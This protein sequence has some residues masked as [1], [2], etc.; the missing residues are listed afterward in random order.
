VDNK[1]KLEIGPG[2]R[3]IDKSWTTLGVVAPKRAVDVEFEWGVQ[4]IPYK[5]NS[6]DL[7]YAC[8]VLEHIRWYNT[9]DALKDAYRALKPGGQLEI[10]VPDFDIIAEGHKNQKPMDKLRRYNDEGDYMLWINSILFCWGEVDYLHKACFNQYHLTNCLNKAGF[11]NL[12]FG[13]EERGRGRGHN[14]NL[15]VRAIK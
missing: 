5:D 4:K 15:G 12:E 7:I 2:K 6:V 11:T 9:V 14:S 3:K 1:I 8:H 10:H 13:I